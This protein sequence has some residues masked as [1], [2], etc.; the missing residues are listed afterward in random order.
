MSRNFYSVSHVAKEFDVSISTIYR[1]V[2]NGILPPFDR[3]NDKL[4]AGYNRDTY[5]QILKL[6]NPECLL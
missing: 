2:R 5:A 6:G 4:P 1:W 3:L